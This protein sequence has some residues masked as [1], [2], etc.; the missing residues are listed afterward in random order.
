[1]TL[2]RNDPF[3]TEVLLQTQATKIETPQVSKEMK[4]LVPG[5]MAPQSNNSLMSKRK[6]AEPSAMTIEERLNVMGIESE[7]N[8]ETLDG[9]IGHIPKTDNLLVL[10]VQGLQSNDAKMLNVKNLKFFFKF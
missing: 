4:V 3:K 1:M 9:E 6:S 10:L 2:K 8:G 5:F 7:Q